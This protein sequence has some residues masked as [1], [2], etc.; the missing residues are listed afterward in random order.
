MRNEE[1]CQH[2][3]M[4]LIKA[5]QCSVVHSSSFSFLSHNKQTFSVNQH[6]LEGETKLDFSYKSHIVSLIA[7]VYFLIL[8]TFYFISRL[9]I[10]NS[11]FLLKFLISWKISIGMDKL[12]RCSNRSQVIREWIFFL[13]LNAWA[14]WLELV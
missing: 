12:G 5:I 4:F 13:N 6:V 14:I 8:T 10:L 9:H 11:N 1:L 3:K 2:F 7:L